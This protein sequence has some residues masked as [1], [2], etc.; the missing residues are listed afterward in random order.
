[1]TAQRLILHVDMDAFFAAVE[2]LDH[3]ELRGK[4]VIVGGGDRGVVSAC[5]YEARAYG[6]RSAMPIGQARRLCPHG[7]FVPGSRGRY[8]E[9]SRQVMAV[10]EGFSPLVEQASIDEAYLDI[11]GQ[12]R[13]F[14]PPE[15]LGARLKA[16]V[17]A[18][19]GLNC[20]VGIA[21][22]KFL[23]KIASDYRKP[24]GL[25]ILRPEEVHGFL[26]T[27]P[28]VRIPGVGGKAGS[29]L[30]ELGVHT[31]GDVLRYPESFWLRRFG[32]W[33]A[34]LHER[35]QGI[36]PREVETDYE[37]KSE[38]AENTFRQDTD[39]RE[40][41]K[42]WLLRQAEEVGRRLRRDGHKGRTVTLKLKFQ[43]FTSITRSK[44]LSA[45][46]CATRVL[47]A[48]AAAL[49]DAEPLPRKLR[50]IGLGVSNFG[51]GPVR[52][53]LLPEQGVLQ[54]DPL[55]KALDAI[56]EKHGRESLV[57]GRVFGFGKKA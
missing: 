55:D 51:S 42:R 54:E 34:M 38:S 4:P 32:K 48:T 53:S 18:A 6:V 28:V 45:P 22:V 12:E 43:D 20:S 49:L 5:S 33:G 37:A 21:P 36:D 15:A 35:A 25:F 14:G 24:D 27:L 17:K 47:F 44:T 9:I 10:L 26:Q 46:T 39:D 23:A 2:Q 8:S 41:L 3:P 40:E 30:A 13:L 52:L 29:R 31:A 57:R 56:R 11:S 7:F 1:M 19:T 50:L 16:E